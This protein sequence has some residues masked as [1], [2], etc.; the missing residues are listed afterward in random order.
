M[1]VEAITDTIHE[2]MYEKMNESKDSEEGTKI[3]H[4]DRK[5]TYQ[6]PQKGGQN[7]FRKVDCIRC[8]APNGN[9]SHD[10]PAKT[11]KCLSC[12]KIGHYARFCRSKQKTD[13]RIKHIQQDSEATS[14]EEDNWTP[15]KIHS[16]NNTVH[17]TG[18]LS[19]DGQP[20]FTVTVLVNNRPIKFIIDSGSPV[21]LIPKQKFNGISTIYPLNEEYRDVNNNKIKFEGKTMANIEIDGEKKKLEL[22]ITTKRTNPLLGLDWRK[23]LGISVNIEKPNTKIQ[24]IQEDPDITDLKKKFKKLFHEN[25]TVK[26][27]EKDIQLKPNAKLMQQKSRPIPIHLRPA[28]GKEIEKL[29]KNGHIEKATDIDENSFVSPAV[30]TVKTDKTIKIALDSR[31]LNEITAK[32]KAQMPDMEEKISRISRKIADGEED[33]IWTSK[34]DLD[35]AYGQLPLSKNARDLCIFAVTGG[36]FTGYYRFLKGFYGLAASRPYSKKR[37][38]KHWRTNIRRG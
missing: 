30:I 14:A 27:I 17:S 35:Y 5:R 29:T 33:E 32:R 28:V 31:K 36:N 22:L 26:G 9:K 8:I 2:Y 4:V 7:K 10:C 3:K 11:K 15:N 1:S 6:R 21:T 23:H 19:K 20:F 13:R 37:L 34:F 18:Q 12:G 16:I 24:N 25:K 38:T